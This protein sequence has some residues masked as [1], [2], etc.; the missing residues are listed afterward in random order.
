[1]ITFDG[2]QQHLSRFSSHQL[3]CNKKKNM[4]TFKTY[5]M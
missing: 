4:F 5:I 2:K 1:M 3:Q